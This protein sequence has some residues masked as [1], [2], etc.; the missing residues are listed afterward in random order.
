MISL[1][2]ELG[3]LCLSAVF[4]H[5]GFQAVKDPSYPATRAEQE[6]DVPEPETAARANGTAMVLA[7]GAIALNIWPRIAALVL[8]LSLIPTTLAGHPFWKESDPQKRNQ[9]K[10]HFEK[11]LGLFGAMVLLVTSRSR[12]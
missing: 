12:R 6:L 2:R 4:I 11:N 3:R 8:A 5:N 1:I 10:L 9:Q 7:G